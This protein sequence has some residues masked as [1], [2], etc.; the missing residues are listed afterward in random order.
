MFRISILGVSCFCLHLNCQSRTCLFC[1]VLCR[2]SGSILYHTY[3]SCQIVQALLASACPE[4]APFLFFSEWK[5]RRRE[6]VKTQKPGRQMC[7]I[8]TAL[9]G[10]FSRK[11][12][13]PGCFSCL[14]A[15]LSAQFLMVKAPSGNLPFLASRDRWGLIRHRPFL[16]TF[17]CFLIPQ[18]RQNDGSFWTLCDF[19]FP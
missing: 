7:G 5:K 15:G 10:S 12:G 8:Q 19:Q 6:T 18:N 13:F 3:P 16:M 9:A 14:P 1:S 11:A 17:Y 2:G 4:T